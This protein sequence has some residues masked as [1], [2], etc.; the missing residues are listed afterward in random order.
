MKS[1]EDQLTDYAVELYGSEFKTVLTVRHLIESHRHLR[2]LSL[3]L[4][5]EKRKAIQLAYDTAHK[6]AMDSTWV[7]WEDLRAMSISELMERLSE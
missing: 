2:S 5:E 4:H 7:K 3:V 6:T 1:N